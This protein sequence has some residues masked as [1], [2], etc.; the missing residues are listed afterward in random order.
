MIQTE[1]LLI[2]SGIN[3]K[4]AYKHYNDNGTMVP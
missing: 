3:D 1:F 4:L 2:A